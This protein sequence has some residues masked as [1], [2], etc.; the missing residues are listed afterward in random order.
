M[1][2]GLRGAA[3]LSPTHASLLRGWGP[4]GRPSCGREAWGQWARALFGLPH[5]LGKKTW[6]LRS[7][8]SEE[9]AVV[10]VC[11]GRWSKG[12]GPSCPKPLGAGGAVLDCMQVLG[13]PGTPVVCSGL[14]G[15]PAQS[16]AS[17]WVDWVARHAGAGRAAWVRLPQGPL[18]LAASAAVGVHAPGFRV[19][20]CRSHCSHSPGGAH[21]EGWA[22]APP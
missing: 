16:R 19:G 2:L 17:G 10:Q 1:C 6:L 13:E 9:T 18:L 5:S 11:W 14:L 15:H 22:Q 8:V 7:R 4:S 12:T 3:G 21:P 20:P